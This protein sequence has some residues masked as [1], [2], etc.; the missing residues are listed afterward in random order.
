MVLR[1]MI[2]IMKMELLYNILF[3]GVPTTQPNSLVRGGN[4]ANPANP[5]NPSNPALIASCG[6]ATLLTAC[7]T[8]PTIIRKLN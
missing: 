7:G 5:A 8:V 2:E 4:P 6:A 3:N 1:I